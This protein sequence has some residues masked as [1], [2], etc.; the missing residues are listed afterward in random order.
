MIT[1]ENLY[2]ALVEAKA[3]LSEDWKKKYQ[4]FLQEEIL[5]FFVKQV[6]TQLN[7]TSREPRLAYFDE[8]IQQDY[9]EALHR[10]KR[11]LITKNNLVEPIKISQLIEDIQAG[12]KFMKVYKQMKMYNDEELNPVLY[13]NKK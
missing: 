2:K 5:L 9:S 6:F 10:F 4:A 12:D 1:Q 13:Q 8:E 7:S 11:G 3:F